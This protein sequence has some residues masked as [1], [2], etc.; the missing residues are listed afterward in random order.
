MIDHHPKI[1]EAYMKLYYKK[2]ELHDFTERNNKD[3]DEK[4]AEINKQINALLCNGFDNENGSYNYYYYDGDELKVR[5]N[6]FAGE[7]E[8]LS[9]AQGETEDETRL[10][11]INK[12]L[13]DITEKEASSIYDVHE[14]TILSQYVQADRALKSKYFKYDAE[15]GFEDILRKN[16]NIM[17]SFELRRNGVPTVPLDVLLQNK[18]YADARNWV[19]SNARFIINK[20]VINYNDKYDVKVRLLR[21]FHKLNRSGNNKSE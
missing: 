5:P 14:G 8:S 21:A 7:K 10:N 17:H 4:I 13:K 11:A 15:F 3:N 20:D 9:I 1:F 16:L 2:V 6:E 12:K 18:Q 19:L